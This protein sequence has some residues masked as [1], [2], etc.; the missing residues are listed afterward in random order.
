MPV[1]GRNSPRRKEQHHELSTCNAGRAS[2]TC[3]MAC[4]IIILLAAQAFMLQSCQNQIG[5]ALLETYGDAFDQL[6][7]SVGFTTSRSDSKL[8]GI[9]TGS[10]DVC[11]AGAG[12]S[13]S[14]LAERYASQLGYKVL[15]VDKRDHVGGNCFDYIDVSEE[16]QVTSLCSS[17]TNLPMLTF[18]S[19]E[20]YR[21]PSIQ[22]RCSFISHQI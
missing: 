18:A 2:T 12:L 17:K 13:G 1:G 22:I 10:Y 4:I 6:V 20:R 16:S 15:V 8:E 14:V 21:S 5:G 11:I 9:L 3:F 19:T 7:S